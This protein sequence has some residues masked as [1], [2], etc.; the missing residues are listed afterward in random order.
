MVFRLLSRAR[1]PS[2]S[3][4]TVSDRPLNNSA[5]IYAFQIEFDLASLEQV[6]ILLGHAS[7]KVTEKHYSPWVKAREE[8]LG[9][10]VRSTL[11]YHNFA[12]RDSEQRNS[13]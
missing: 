7:I 4:V 3:I 11:V 10:A 8:Q 5:S 9:A 1:L 12:T 13:Q 2:N 6:S